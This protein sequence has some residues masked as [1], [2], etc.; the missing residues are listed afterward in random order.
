MAVDTSIVGTVL[1]RA[2][3][4]VERGPVTAFARAVTDRNPVYADPSAAE[5][6]DFDAIPAPPT[7]PIAFDFWGRFADD[8]PSDAMEGNRINEIIAK[9]LS[10]GGLLLHGEQEFTYH[11]TPKVGDVLDG[12]GKVVDTYEKESKG[13]TMTFVVSDTT[14]RDVA[15]GEPVVTSRNV[16]IVRK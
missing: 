8:Q 10:G 4:R 3:V 5:G 2:R 6:A 11:R 9:L 7:F 14:Y 13:R 16:L 1:S 15:T 12:E